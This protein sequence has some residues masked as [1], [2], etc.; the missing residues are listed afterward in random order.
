MKKKKENVAKTYCVEV[1]K[2]GIVERTWKYD[3]L[4]EQTKKFDELQNDVSYV[5]E[6]N[7]SIRAFSIKKEATH[8]LSSNEKQ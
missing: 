4:E 8:A 2:H 7:M 3:T 1:K 5:R 6:Q